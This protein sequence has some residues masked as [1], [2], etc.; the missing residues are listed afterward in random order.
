MMNRAGNKRIWIGRFYDNM[1]QGI[2]ICG[3]VQLTF[4]GI[5]TFSFIRAK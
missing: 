1:L 2:T 3:Y 5:K 4:K